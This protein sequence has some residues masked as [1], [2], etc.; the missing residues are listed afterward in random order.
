[1]NP[2]MMRQPPARN[3]RLVDGPARADLAVFGI[4]GSNP[5]LSAPESRLVLRALFRSLS[6]NRPAT[7]LNDAQ[8]GG[9]FF[10]QI[11]PVRRSG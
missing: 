1:M 8:L 3:R 4:G 7:P 10:A 11:W 9:Y 5:P 6:S 2:S